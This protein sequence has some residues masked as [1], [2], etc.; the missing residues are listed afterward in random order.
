MADGTADRDGHF[1][2]R[3]FAGISYELHAVWQGDMRTGAISA[4]PKAIPAGSGP[5]SLR[6]VLD[7]A[8]DSLADAVQRRSLRQ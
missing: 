5:L 2:L 8:G 4:V 3:V 1:G 7:Q 6:L